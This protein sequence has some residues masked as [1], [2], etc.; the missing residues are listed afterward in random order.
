M[1]KIKLALLLA[2][3]AGGVLG[4]LTGQAD[5]FAGGRMPSVSLPMCVACAGAFVVGLLVATGQSSSYTQP[6]CSV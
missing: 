1:N 6:L 4:A 3:D 5:K 2:L